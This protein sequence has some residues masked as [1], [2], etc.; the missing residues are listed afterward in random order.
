LEIQLATIAPFICDKTIET[1]KY[2]CGNY[3]TLDETWGT[4][5]PLDQTITITT[6]RRRDVPAGETNF[7]KEIKARADVVFQNTWLQIVLYLEC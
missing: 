3:E 2:L 1:L 4:V 6:H 5:T 7:K